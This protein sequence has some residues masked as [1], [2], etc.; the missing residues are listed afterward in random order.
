MNLPV[1][2]AQRERLIGQSKALHGKWRKLVTQKAPAAQRQKA[3]NAWKACLNKISTLDASISKVSP[4]AHTASMSVAKAIAK[5]EGGRGP[6]GRYHPYQDSVKVWT[7]GFGHTNAAGGLHVGPSTPSLSSDEAIALL[8]HDLNTI[9]A[10]GVVQYLKRYDWPL[11]Q[12]R[13]DA[14]V[15]FAFNLGTGYFAT[16]HDIGA[17]MKRHNLEGVA[18]AMLE[19]DRAGGVVLDGLR[20]RRTWERQLLLGGTYNNAG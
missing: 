7:I 1:M 8:L 9:Y 20:R 13:F 15:D 19:Y 3:F 10:P 14:L 2:K 4:N 5:W 12:D 17:Q 18:N 6:D 16:D 11:R